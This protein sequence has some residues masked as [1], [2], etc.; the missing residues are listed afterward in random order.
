M[1]ARAASP[2]AT[3]GRHLRDNHPVSDQ[4]QWRDGPRPPWQPTPP[5]PD[6]VPRAVWAPGGATAAPGPLAVASFQ[7][8]RDEAIRGLRSAVLRGGKLARVAASTLTTF[9]L[10]LLVALLPG[11]PGF[12]AGLLVGTGLVPLLAV[13]L[14]VLAGPA[15]AWARNPAAGAPQ[16]V[17]FAEDGLETTTIFAASRIGWQGVSSAFE[18]G[19]FLLLKAASGTGYHVVPKRAF[20]SRAELDVACQLVRRHVAGADVAAGGALRAR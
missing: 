15:R 6:P 9:A 18:T 1:R 11:T 16:R 17:A 8:G 3:G 4:W 19:E 13:L 14:T 12:V 20:G 2:G 7:L 10:V 5:P